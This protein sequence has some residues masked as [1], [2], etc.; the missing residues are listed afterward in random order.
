MTEYKLYYKHW[1]KLH[2]VTFQKQK[3]AYQYEQRLLKACEIAINLKGKPIT[4][5]L[6]KDGSDWEQYT[7]IGNR[8]ITV[9][10]LEEIMQI[11][12]NEAKELKES[13]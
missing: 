11:L 4:R 12:K 5:M 9:S 7:V 1:G 13:Q 6:K 2:D 3:S 10:E 8:I